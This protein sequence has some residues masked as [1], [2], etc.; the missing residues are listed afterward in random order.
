MKRRHFIHTLAAVPLLAADAQRKAPFRVLYSND[1]TNITSCVSPFH[2]AHE[3]FRAEM[4]D[5]TVDEVAGLVDAHFLQPGLGV[6]PLWPS[7]VIDLIIKR[8]QLN[9]CTPKQM[10]MLKRFGV[11]EAESYSFERASALISARMFI[12]IPCG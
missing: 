2:A 11:N 7:K 12:R 9:L 10:R 3:P 4:L 8:S 5:A 1:L 6:V